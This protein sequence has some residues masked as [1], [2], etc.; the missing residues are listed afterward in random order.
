MPEFTFNADV[1]EAFDGLVQEF[2]EVEAVIRLG[3]IC[4]SKTYVMALRDAWAQD[5]T[6]RAHDLD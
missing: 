4:R 2:G 6:H 5:Q 1:I 3:R